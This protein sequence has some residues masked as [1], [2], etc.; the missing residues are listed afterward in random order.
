MNCKTGQDWMMVGFV[1]VG[2]FFLILTVLNVNVNIAG[3]ENKI[4]NK[5]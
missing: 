2:F 4:K 1:V 5:K 3:I